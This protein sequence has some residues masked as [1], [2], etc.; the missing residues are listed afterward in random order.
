MLG[1]SEHVTGVGVQGDKSKCN[2]PRTFQLT[3]NFSFT[4]TNGKLTRENEYFNRLRA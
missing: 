3:E 2:Y 4:E 1:Q